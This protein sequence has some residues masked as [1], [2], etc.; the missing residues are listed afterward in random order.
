MAQSLFYG[1]S[2]AGK[3]PTNNELS[4]IDLIKQDILNSFYTRKGERVMYPQ[5][6]SIIWDMLY[7]PLTETN[8]ELIINDAIDII[9]SEPRVTLQD[10]RVGEFEHGI[11]LEIDVVYTPFNA[12]G[13][14]EIDFDRRADRQV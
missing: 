10:T 8:K 7:E 11:R 9:K 1:F 6:G 12:V 4:D 3:G 5:F 14:L 13:T 2:T